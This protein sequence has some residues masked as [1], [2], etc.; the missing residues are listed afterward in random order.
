MGTDAGEELKKE[1]GDDALAFFGEGEVLD[2]IL[3]ELPEGLVGGAA[4]SHR[5]AQ[6]RNV[7]GVWVVMREH[8]ESFGDEG[9]RVVREADHLGGLEVKGRELHVDV[10]RSHAGRDLEVADVG[11]EVGMRRVSV[12]CV[13]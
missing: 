2:E 7:R 10:V 13:V 5:H 9:L 8:L 11:L 12:V 4:G 1:C 3:P 6:R